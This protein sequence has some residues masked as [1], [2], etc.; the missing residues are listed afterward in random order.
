M[1]MGSALQRKWVGIDFYSAKGVDVDGVCSVKGV[2]VNEVCS[3]MGST[4]QRV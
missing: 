1:W 4:L 2:D 3:P